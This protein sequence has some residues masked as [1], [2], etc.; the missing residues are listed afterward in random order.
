MQVGVGYPRCPLP[1]PVGVQTTGR[2]GL[3]YPRDLL[4]V[5][6]SSEP[7]TTGDESA[8]AGKGESSFFPSLSPWRRK[9]NQREMEGTGNLGA[10]AFL[11]CRTPSGLDSWKGRVM[12]VRRGPV[13][14]GRLNVPAP[15]YLH[16]TRNVFFLRLSL[17]TNA[18]TLLFLRNSTG[19]LIIIN[20]S[21]KCPQSNNNYK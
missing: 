12:K 4:L 1:K 20:N 8:A 9:W 18:I 15:S 16:Q 5:S 19:L 13:V 2:D 11:P 14:L 21:I 10:A 17:A 7:E 6:R 3:G